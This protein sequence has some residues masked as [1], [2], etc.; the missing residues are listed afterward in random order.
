ME[1]YLAQRFVSNLGHD[2]LRVLTALAMQALVPVGFVVVP[3]RANPPAC[4][5][6]G[7]KSLHRNRHVSADGRHTY[8]L[9][10]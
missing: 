3:E 10:G 1:T 7:A 8:S 6:S 2:G 5:C 4:A 9:T